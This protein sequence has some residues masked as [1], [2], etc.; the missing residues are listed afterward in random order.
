M[1]VYLSKP[2]AISREH[3]YKVEKDIKELGHEVTYHLGG[4]YSDHDLINADVV[5]VITENG[6]VSKGS[7]TEV[8]KA[9]K[10]DK[11]VY[12]VDIYCDHE[13][14]LV[15]SCNTINTS[16]WGSLNYGETIV[17]EDICFHSWNEI[18]GINSKNIQKHDPVTFEPVDNELLLCSLF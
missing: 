4:T 11:E 13:I 16:D 2:A 17:D 6:S 12:E 7:L 18:L 10:L 15:Y 14:Y 8:E 1:K 5:V 3:L 9:L